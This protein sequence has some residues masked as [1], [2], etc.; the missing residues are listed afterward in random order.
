MNNF[1]FEAGENRHVSS[2]RQT[3][4]WILQLLFQLDMNPSDLSEVWEEFWKDYSPSPAAKRYVEEVVTGV[5]EN[6][7]T[8]DRLIKEYARNWEV[9]RMGVVDRNVM[10][11]AIYEMKYRED[12]PP[13][14]S[15]NE[16]VDIARYFSTGDSAR[17]VNGILDHA[18]RD[19]GRPSRTCSRG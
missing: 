8:I 15:I 2:R 1:R 11:M 7:D 12:V 4:E 6:L 17:F 14:V 10:R 5:M 3:R 9:V 13:V 19:I 16:A 18:L